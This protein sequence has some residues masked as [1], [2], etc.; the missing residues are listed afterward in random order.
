VRGTEEARLGDGFIVLGEVRARLG[1]G[2][3]RRAEL[4]WRGM[5][6]GPGV[7]LS[8]CLINIGCGVVSTSELGGGRVT[9][10]ANEVRA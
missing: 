4:Y 7:N 9:E 8:S 5:V 10:E 2:G 1:L 6:S 3:V